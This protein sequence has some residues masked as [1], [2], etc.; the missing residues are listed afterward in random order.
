MFEKYE[1]DEKIWKIWKLR[2]SLK[3]I[4]NSY[5]FCI[6]IL[7]SL[8]SLL[9]CYHHHFILLCLLLCH[10]HRHRHHHHSMLMIIPMV[11]PMVMPL[12]IWVCL[13]SKTIWIG[14][15]LL[16]IIRIH[17]VFA[18]SS[19]I[20]SSRYVHTWTTTTACNRPPAP[21]PRPL[22]E[23]EENHWKIVRKS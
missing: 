2:T 3:I 21:Q 23:N 10:H 9:L 15:I 4:L 22:W 12:F 8:L 16:K 14:I 5:G 1:D 17:M 18:S 19:S 7:C 11:L 6:I 13:S 20:G